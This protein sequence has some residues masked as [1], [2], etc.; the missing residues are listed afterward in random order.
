M[1]GFGKSKNDGNDEHQ[2]LYYHQKKEAGVAEM[3]RFNKGPAPQAPKPAASGAPRVFEQTVQFP[4]V[5]EIKVIG[6][7]GEAGG[8]E[9]ETDMVKVVAEVTGKNWQEIAYS[10]RDTSSG[11]YRSLTI[12]VGNG[13]HI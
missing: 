12:Q 2:L 4:T 1:Q 3:L 11:K 8:S 6:E 13:R 10:S 7:P 9:F 5:F